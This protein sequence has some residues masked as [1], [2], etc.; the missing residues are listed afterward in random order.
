MKREPITGKELELIQRHLIIN[1]RGRAFFGRQRRRNGGDILGPGFSS[2]SEAMIRYKYDLTMKSNQNFE[3]G[4]VGYFAEKNAVPT[5]FSR[6]VTVMPGYGMN[7][8]TVPLLD[9]TLAREEAGLSNEPFNPREERIFTEVFRLMHK[10]KDFTRSLYLR[11]EASMMMPTFETNPIVKKRL[12]ERTIESAEE[13][14]NM[15]ANNQL[16]D[17]ASKY[18]FVLAFAT[19]TRSQ[20]D[21]CNLNE[22]GIEKTKDREVSDLLFALTGGA[23]G[24]RK[25]ADKTVMINGR[26]NHYAQAS[27]ERTAF[28]GSGIANQLIAALYTPIRV[29]LD[30]Y[31]FTYKHRSPAE[32]LAKIKR[33]K[34]AIGAD[35]HQHD[36]LIAPYVIDLYCKLL[37]EVF[38]PRVALMVDMMLHA[39][40]YVPNPDVLVK[41]DGWWLGNPFNPDDFTAQVGLPSGIANN[42]DI[43]KWNMTATYL[44]ELDYITHDVL[45]EGIDKILR[46]ESAKYGLLNMADDGVI[47]LNQA[48]HAQKLRERWETMKDANGTRATKAKFH[49]IGIEMPVVFL[50]DV[51]YVDDRRELCVA[52]NP[53]SYFVNFW[54]PEYPTDMRPYWPIGWEARQAHYTMTPLYG[55]MYNLQD[56]LFYNHF[57]Q[58]LEHV[59][60]DAKDKM[61]RRIIEHQRRFS[62]VT[63]MAYLSSISQLNTADRDYLMNPDAIFYKISPED[64]SDPVRAGMTKISGDFI[65]QHLQQ[66][67]H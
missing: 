26:E 50:G 63:D 7:P 62:N 52:P 41:Q 36:Q 53:V 22:Y 23:E 33:F 17:L 46:G 38:D 5:D 49:R 29:Y 2:L 48:S 43:G 39:P 54:C 4:T 34:H 32:K 20:A 15:L 55:S 13:I 44:C 8:L 10:E 21:T 60:K 58:R 24:T 40:T 11:P 27:R 67:Y 35:V 56:E 37:Y 61:Q 14:F 30:T 28:G 3:G 16:E 31:S 66:Y 9:N 47:L 42:P 65:G 12:V 59:V 18:M 64:L 25:P 19:L 51:F 1:D 45:E 6:L 57:N